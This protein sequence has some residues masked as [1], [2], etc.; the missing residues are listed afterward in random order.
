MYPLRIT[1]RDQFPDCPR[2]YTSAVARTSAARCRYCGLP[3]H[4]VHGIRLRSMLLLSNVLLTARVGCS[5][6]DFDVP[7]KCQT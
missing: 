2:N 6:R 5:I 7:R 3:G 4:F 1:W